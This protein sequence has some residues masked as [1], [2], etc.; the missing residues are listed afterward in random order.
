[1]LDT[2][3][4]Y[5]SGAMDSDG[6]FT[7]KRSTY[8]MRVRNEA[9]NAIYSEKVGLHQVTPIVPELLKSHFGGNCHLAKPQTPNSKP[10]YR[11]T[12]T[13]LA[14]S[15]ACEALLPY[16]RIKRR[17]VELILEL[18]KSKEMP[19]GQLAY[20]FSEEFPGWRDMELWTTTQVVEALGYAGPAMVAQA[21]RNGTIL[22]LNGNRGGIATPRMPRLLIERLAEHQTRSKDRRG[23]NRPPQLI[24]W[25]ERLWAEVRELN[26][27]GVNG[28]CLKNAL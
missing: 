13:D 16:L 8:C 5:L 21:I 26:K 12:A 9:N 18:R 27:I 25:R 4:A 17:Q 2:D 22:S 10:M 24:A 7:I 14:A 19:Y 11:W 1:M 28:L 23:R 3:L 6:Y 20:W 15:K